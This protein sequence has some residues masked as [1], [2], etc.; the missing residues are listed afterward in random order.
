MLVRIDHDGRRVRQA[1]EG[2]AC[3]LFEIVG[4]QEIAAVRRVGVHAEVVALPELDNRSER[5]HG[6]CRRRADGRDDGAHA[7]SRQASFQRVHIHSPP[8]IDRNGLERQAQHTGDALMCVVRLGGRENRLAVM[9]LAGDPERFEVR[10]RPTAAQVAQVRFPA[11]HAR[12]RCDGFLLH[13]GTGPTAVERVVVGIDLQGHFVGEARDGVWRFEHLAGVQRIAVWIVVF[14]ALRDFLQ[15]CF[16]I[17]LQT[18]SGT[19]DPRRPECFRA[20]NRDPG[21]RRAS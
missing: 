21:R 20:V 17:S 18:P 3:L 1:V 12:E 14:Q 7:A 10:H 16:E 4:K 8:A 19:S 13:R 6:T 9:E 11:D 5:V 15:H 2:A